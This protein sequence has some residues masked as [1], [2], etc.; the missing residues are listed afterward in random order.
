VNRWDELVVDWS[1][2]KI[3]NITQDT[4][5]PFEPLT[6]GDQLMLE[7]GGIIGYLHERNKAEQDNE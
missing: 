5:I 2:D 7:A 6:E 1:Q 3:F 4:E